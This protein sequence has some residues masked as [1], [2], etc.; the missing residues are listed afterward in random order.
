LRQQSGGDVARDHALAALNVCC[1]NQRLPVTEIVRKPDQLNK[2]LLF[3]PLY[4]RVK[5]PREF[6]DFANMFASLGVTVADGRR[7]LRNAGPGARLRR[8]FIRP[9][10]L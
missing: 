2:V 1:A 9:G 3:A 4:E 6:P 10:A 7:R 5:L 8:E